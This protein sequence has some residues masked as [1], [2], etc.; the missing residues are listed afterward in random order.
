[1]SVGCGVL[2]ADGGEGRSSPDVDVTD[3]RHPAASRWG[4]RSAWWRG[5]RPEGRGP[6]GTLRSGRRPP[7]RVTSCG[8]LRAA[9]SPRWFDTSGTLVSLASKFRRAWRGAADSGRSWP[10]TRSARAG[11]AGRIQ[12]GRR[13]QGPPVRTAS[14]GRRHRLAVEILRPPPRYGAGA[15]ITR[16]GA[17]ADMRLDVVDWRRGCRPPEG[18]RPA[19]HPAAVPVMRRPRAGRLGAQRAAA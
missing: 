6:C 3:H 8:M 10:A 14:P 18:R 19:L 15:L 16:W 13:G 9:Q 4:M 1:M 7:P 5:N 17:D 12:T 11:G 2:A